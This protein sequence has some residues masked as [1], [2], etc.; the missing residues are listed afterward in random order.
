VS[1]FRYVSLEVSERTRWRVLTP[2]APRSS[3]V[4]HDLS[5]EKERARVILRREHITSA[6]PRR[7]LSII[8]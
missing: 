4:F 6:F 2:C 1:A 8:P 5:S 7:T 3:V